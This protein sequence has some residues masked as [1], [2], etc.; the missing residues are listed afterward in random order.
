MRQPRGLR[1]SHLFL[2][3]VGPFMDDWGQTLGESKILS[4][5]EKVEIIAAFLDGF[6]RQDHAYGYV[7]AYRGMVQGLS[8]GLETL[9]RDLP[10]DLYQTL[11]KSKFATLAQQPRE[12]FEQMYRQKLESF[13]CPITGQRF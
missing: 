2:I 13:D 8:E 11:K 10:V 9:A 5:Q 4:T 6:S 12:E 1:K 3:P 7:R